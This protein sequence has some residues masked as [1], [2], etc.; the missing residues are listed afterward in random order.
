MKMVCQAVQAST[1]KEKYRR[2]LGRSKIS[3]DMRD[4]A[5]AFPKLQEAR[6]LADHDPAI[7]FLHR[8]VLSLI[9]SADAA[10]MAFDRA[11][12]AERDDVLALMMVR[13]RD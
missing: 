13:T 6:H 7:A 4:F 1:L 11:E 5:D 3:P 9:D 8:E 2:H 12:P 10:M